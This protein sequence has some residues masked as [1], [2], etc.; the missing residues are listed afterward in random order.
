MGD[1][2]NTPID[3]DD[4]TDLAQWCSQLGIDEGRLRAVVLRVGSMPAAVRTY[5][6]AKGGPPRTLTE[7]MREEFATRQADRA[8]RRR[9]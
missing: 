3:V 2:P 9:T 8:S 6:L 1:L 5:L 4:P 7:P